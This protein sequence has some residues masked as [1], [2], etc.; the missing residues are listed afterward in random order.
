MIAYDKT[1]LENQFL[2]DEAHSLQKANFISKDEYKKIVAVLPTLK[3]NSNILVRIGFSFL[4]LLLYTSFCGFIS[5]FGF[6]FIEHN[7]EIFIF[8]YA[9]IGF[10]GLE[11]FVRQKY[12]GHGLDDTFLIG[13]QLVLAIAVG[14]VSDGYE[15]E[16]ALI[17]T[18]ISL[19]SYLRYVNLISVL[20]F[21]VSSTATVAYSL[22]ELGSIGK[23]ILPFVLMLFAIGIYF[24]CRKF[25]QKVRFPFYHKGLLFL[26]NFGLILFYCAG[27]YFVV[28][29]LSEILLGI[30]LTPNM[31]IPFAWVFYAF[32][33]IVP[34]FYIFYA[35]KTQNR[36]QLWIG[37]L[38]TVSSIFTIRYYHEIIPTAIALTLGGLLLFAI[39][40]FSI[41][42]IKDKTTGITFQPDR[43]INT[44]DFIHTEAFILTS[45]F[46]LKPEAPMA[47]SPMEFGGG[48]FSGGGS[49][50]S[51]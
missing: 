8:I 18:I 23:T 26:K 2:I 25:T 4:A 29:E 37:F 3:S 47:E 13:S 40:Y 1:E 10:V 32:T 14:V 6:D 48:G 20:I 34:A 39:A 9:I 46:G 35:L 15:L 43:F 7:Y 5:L 51:Y 12:Y 36:T 38:T 42:K 28:R 24:L 33:S 19:I 44:N 45:Q 27:N 17:A 50:G 16:I 41:K 11:F 30:E 49:D 31:D 22:L 21:C